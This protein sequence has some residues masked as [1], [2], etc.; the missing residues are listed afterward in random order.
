MERPSRFAEWVAEAN[1][2]RSER[3]SFLK[4]RAGPA[5]QELP[6]SSQAR[7]TILNGV[8]THFKR[9]APLHGFHQSMPARLDMENIDRRIV[10]IHRLI[11]N[12]AWKAAWSQDPKALVSA[13]HMIC[14]A[15]MVEKADSTKGRMVN[16]EK[17]VNALSRKK[18]TK[19]ES[20]KLLKT[21]AGKDYWALAADVFDGFHMIE[22]H[23]TDQKY[24]TVDVGPQV[25]MRC[26]QPLDDQALVAI[27]AQ[28]G[29]VE[30][31]AEYWGPLPRYLICVAMNFGGTNSPHAFQKVMREPVRELRR[32]LGK[33]GGSVI[34]YLDDILFLLPTYDV[35][36]QARAIIEQVLTRYGITRHPKKGFGFSDE[37]RQEFVHLGSGVSLSRGVLF[38]PPAKQERLRQQGTSLL[39]SLAKH[40]RRVD[41]YWLIQFARFAIS[42]LLP[43]SQAWYRTRALF[44]DLVRCGA[45]PHKFRCMA[46]SSPTKACG[47]SNG[48]PS[49][50]LTPIWVV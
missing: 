39:R 8:R 26:R 12:G 1:P 23:P 15:F 27:K 38:V 11:R 34:V 40:Q 14:P 30:D 4:A 10:E 7:R 33:L 3:T 6:S 41:A 36:I 9:R 42:N 37:P 32:E 29:E 45:H 31:P 22:N 13:G 44:D 28:V 19:F 16:N 43:L 2:A 21:C 46:P 50:L 17:R 20:L 25:E 49:S 48:G 24:H 18:K 35:A 47:I 5:W